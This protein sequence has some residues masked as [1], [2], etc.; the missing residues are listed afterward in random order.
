MC[1]IRARALLEE[2][3]KVFV[4][5]KAHRLPVLSSPWHI[6]HVLSQ[7]DVIVW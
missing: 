3:C 5:T 4:N 1:P 6:S 2:A 7:L